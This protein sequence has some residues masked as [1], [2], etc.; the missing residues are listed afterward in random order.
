MQVNLAK[1][2]FFGVFSGI[3]LCCFWGFVL[4]IEKEF[5]PILEKYLMVA[6]AVCGYATIYVN[7]KVGR[8]LS[9]IVFCMSYVSAVAVSVYVFCAF[10]QVVFYW[11]RG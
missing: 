5:V 3:S 6:S 10:Y 9:C 8:K 7:T 11:S 2:V 4:G 1:P